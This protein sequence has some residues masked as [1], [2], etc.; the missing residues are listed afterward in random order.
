MKHLFNKALITENKNTVLISKSPLWGNL[1][2]LLLLLLVLLAS[3]SETDNYY[4]QLKKQPELVK[5]YD[6]V[7]AVNDTLTIKGHFI[8]DGLQIKIGDTAANIISISNKLNNA[9]YNDSIQVVKLIVTNAMGVGTARPVSIT[10]SG[11]TVS[12]PAIEIVENSKAGLLPNG[13]TVQKIADY[14]ANSTPVYCRSGN[15]NLYF[16]NKTTNTVTRMMPDGTLTQVFDPSQ[17]KDADGTSFTV[18]RLNGCGIDPHEQYLYLS[19]YTEAPS[20]TYYHYYRLCRWDL[21]N[22]T[23][24]VL[25]KTPYYIYKSKRMLSDAQPFEGSISQVKMFTATGIYPDSVGNVYFD[26]DNRMITRMDATGN[27]SYVL[28]NSYANYTLTDPAPQIV[29]PATSDYYSLPR[30][31][32]FFP[33]VIANYMKIEAM[34]PD[35]KFL[36]V[37]QTTARLVRYDLTNQVLLNTFNAWLDAMNLNLKKPF[38]SGSF[39]VLTGT[40]NNKNSLWGMMPLQGGKLLILYYQDLITGDQ[41]GKYDL[42]AWG[43]LDFVNE[44]GSRYAPGGFLRQ[45]YVMNYGTDELLNRDAQGMLYMTANNKSVILKTIYQ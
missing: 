33:G 10:S 41:T 8:A 42:P 38:I 44:R 6:A 37:Q 30:T 7:Y 11:I 29:N 21:V 27:Y 5:D 22:H 34:S 26:M 20:R 17:C 1:G 28:K 23:F 3:C 19:L 16:I 39:A 4:A 45:G 18:T 2:R 40:T 31:L 24:T 15:G 25:N 43:I 32:Q 36:Y 13:L 35:E 9:T 14:P 12:G